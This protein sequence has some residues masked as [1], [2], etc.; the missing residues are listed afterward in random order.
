MYTKVKNYL[1]TVIFIFLTINAGAL[2]QTLTVST[3]PNNH[4]ASYEDPEGSNIVMLQ[5]Q[6]SANA[7]IT[8]TSITVAPS[9]SGIRRNEIIDDEILIYED[10]NHNGVLD[11]GL[12]ELITSS[13][14][15][16][17]AG[18]PPSQIAI[19]I[20]DKTILNGAIQNWIIVHNFEAA[21]N[22]DNMS[23]RITSISTD[24]GNVSG[25]PVN[26]STKTFRTNP[27][28]VSGSLF[29]GQAAKNPIARN[30]SSSA[31]D[32]VMLQMVVAASTLESGV[33]TQIDFDMSGSANEATDI[34]RAR[35]FYD[36]DAN[37]ILNLEQDAQ[38]GNT[39]TSFVNNGVLSFSGL[40]R[41]ID[42]GES[43]H[44]IVVYDLN[45]LA[46]D[47]ETFQ[48]DL[49]SNGD[50]SVTGLTV[51]GAPAN[52]NVAT[53]SSTGSLTLSAGNY[54]PTARTISASE[55]ELEMIQVNLAANAT[56][57]INITSITFKTSG[58]ANESADIDSVVLINDINA[59]GRYDIVYDNKIGNTITSFTD[60]G[61]ITFSGLSQTIT[62]GSAEDW[63]LLYYLNGNGSTDETFK[64]YFD[65]STQISATGVTST[66]S[67]SP[68]G[69]P[70]NGN[71]MTISSTGTL[72]ISLADANPGS[73][74]FGAGASN[75]TMMAFT[76]ASNDIEDIQINSLTIR[77]QTNNI[78]PNDL[79]NNDIKIY[80]D[81]DK[82]GLLNESIDRF[83]GSQ[84]YGGAPPQPLSSN[85]T[86]SITNETV[87]ANSSVQWII[88]HSFSG[89]SV[90]DYIQIS[91]LTSDVS[92]SGSVS[93]SSSNIAGNNMDG[94]VKTHATGVSGSLTLSEGAQNPLFRYISPGT[95][96]E[97]MLQFQL[98]ANSI[99]NIDITQIRI[100]TTGTGNESNDLDSIRLY[101]DNDNDGSLNILN[102][103][104]LGSTVSSMTDN[105]TL[106][107][108]GFSNVISAGNAQNF[109][110]V[111]NFNGTN[112]VVGETFRVFTGNELITATG[113]TSS[114]GIVP[115]GGPANGETVTITNTGTINVSAGPANPGNTNVTNA[116][117][118]V[119]TIQLNVA[120]GS[121][122]DVTVTDLTLRLSGTFDDGTDFEGSSFRLYVDDNNN[123]ALDMGET[124]IGGNQTCSADNGFVTFSGFTQTLQAGTN[125]NYILLTNLNGNASNFENFR[126]SFVNSTDIIAYGVNTTNTIYA[127]GVPVQGGLFTVSA[128]GSLSLILGSNNPAAGTEANNAQS[129]EILQLRLSASGVENINVTSITFTASGTG[130]DVS[131]LSNN[132]TMLYRDANNDGL[133][134]A[135]DVQLGTAGNYSAD[136]G[137][138]TFSPGATITAGAYQNWLLV[139]NFSGSASNGQTF[140]AGIYNTSQITSTG[141]SS[142]S[143]ITETG[144][145]IVGNYKT[146]GTVGS[147]SVLIGDYNPGTAEIDAIDDYEML[148]F[149]L[150]AS[151]IENVEVNSFTVTHQGTGDAVNDIANNGVHLVRDVNNNGIY[152]SGT[153]NILASTNYSGSTATFTLAPVTITANTTENWLVMYDFTLNIFGGETFQARFANLT[154]L[155]LTGATS[156]QPI[157][158]GGSVPISGGTM[159]VSND[160]S[161]PV[162]LI[163]FE[164]KGDNGFIK[165]T[166]QTASEVNNLGF[167]LER[168]AAGSQSFDYVASYN[169][170]R[171]LYGQ[172]TTSSATDYSYNDSTV[173][174]KTEYMYRLIQYD[175][176]GTVLIQN[177]TATGTAK[178]QLPKN[179][180]LGQ[181]YPNPFNPLTNI[182]FAL[183][184]AA[185]VKLVIFNILGQEI[186]SLVN[187][188]FDAG[189]HEV[190]WNGSNSQGIQTAS[191][192]Y[193]YI[194][195]IKTSA[196]NEIVKKQKMIKLK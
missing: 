17:G 7:D 87:P 122:E 125:R 53:I 184:A 24:I 121:N 152:D 173:I 103:T 131:A 77:P 140:R 163:S 58:T 83:I 191:G 175:Y 72:T 90:S 115:T 26:G 51:S 3:G 14:Y 23:A 27:G 20:P 43:E 144:L 52:G 181:N 16:G 107:F 145:P 88:V 63:V 150:T 169:D 127:N 135:G 172:G 151:S 35:L 155:N 159:T 59:N 71:N 25:T 104:Q 55:S 133:L 22:N 108:S 148:Q 128:T 168:K 81:I 157:T 178:E 45:G 28:T 96:D 134:D 176:D 84:N 50:M 69:L 109:I 123:G 94:G 68:L 13:N 54:N 37:G 32:E 137:T 149:K 139:Y 190:V 102:D 12:D 1:L 38:I 57:D 119:V 41:T 8:I 10:K 116:D 76:L 56:E 82:N 188:E 105:D 66:Q 167:R 111:H 31:S 44:W 11:L 165:L 46:S 40:T 177:I 192:L 147:M 193:F 114:S 73:E 185:K 179:F 182:K 9:A 85:A 153:D 49:T 141:V 18:G 174:P 183:P 124:Q 180:E 89:T 5:M 101:L 189:I 91:I 194:M 75:V 86:I 98:A 100:A 112:N 117:N 130:N 47:G 195:Q 78:T 138:R 65:V 126:V 64:T 164:A 154:H 61:D 142:G 39:I 120:V 29:V 48:V 170:N 106:T 93:L 187:G 160:F 79:V 30:V 161:L 92:A 146:I 2:A 4:A 97:T 136:D 132:T 186:L 166:W 70:V 60:N 62:A 196:G 118:N 21:D 74:N 143:S 36:G 42:A 67:I 95:Q 19:S 6:L 99:E 129:V 113:V 162:E 156:G 171:A 34:T 158:A 15:N 33:I 110:V 80:Q